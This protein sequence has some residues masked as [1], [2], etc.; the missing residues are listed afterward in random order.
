MRAVLFA[1]NGLALAIFVFVSGLITATAFF[2][3]EPERHLDMTQDTAGL[4]T[5]QAVKVDTSAQKFERVAPRPVPK[6]ALVTTAEEKVSAALPQ[7][8]TDLPSVPFEQTD[9]ATLEPQVQINDAQVEWCSSRYRSYRPS[10]NSYLSYS[11]RRREC[12]SPY[13][14]AA[15]DGISS[16]PPTNDVE[17]VGAIPEPTSAD[18]ELA[19]P[20]AYPD[21]EHVESCFSR[22]RSYRPEDNSYQ[23][24]DG[25]PR[26]QCR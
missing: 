18:V 8:G 23:P 15:G 13:S 11:G 2:S 22:Y 26:R 24:F 7:A 5:T 12:V 19:Y 3:A 10:D 16:Y 1:L 6:Q 4:W 21:Q 14:D 25:G 17:F 20:Q 9:Q